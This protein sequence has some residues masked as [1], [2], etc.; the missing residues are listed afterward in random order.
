MMKASYKVWLGSKLKH[1]P[2]QHAVFCTS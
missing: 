1:F 2:R